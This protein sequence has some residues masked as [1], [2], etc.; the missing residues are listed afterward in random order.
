MI[1]VDIKNS[2]A[3]TVD[4]ILHTFVYTGGQNKQANV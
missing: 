4:C 1:T 2:L 3:D